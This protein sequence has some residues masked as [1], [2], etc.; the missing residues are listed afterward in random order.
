[1]KKTSRRSF[2]KQL[3]G[4]IATLPVAS[5]ALGETVQ[6]KKKRSQA[7]LDFFKEHDTPP[8]VMVAEGSVT[9][10]TTDPFGLP[11]PAGIGR[12]KHFVSAYDDLKLAHIKIVDGSGE[13]VY[14]NDKPGAAEVRILITGGPDVKLGRIADGFYIDLPNDNELGSPQTLDGKRKARY[15]PKKSTDKLDIQAIKIAESPAANSE[16][17]F[18][19]SRG[20]LNSKLKE[21]RIMLW[22]EED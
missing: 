4:A 17:L 20:D 18:K 21:C 6:D 13:I 9:V 7:Q 2:G 8:P 11:G 22:L 15:T 5:L 19:I 10:E 1:M 12:K 3:A 14:R 16:L